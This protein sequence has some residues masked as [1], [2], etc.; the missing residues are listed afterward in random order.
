MILLIFAIVIALALFCLLR[1]AAP[2]I[3]L[4][5]FCLYMWHQGRQALGH[6]HNSAA[7]AASATAAAPVPAPTPAAADT[8]ATPSP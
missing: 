4:L 5:L 1:K 2:F 7:A 3:I 6:D 8:P